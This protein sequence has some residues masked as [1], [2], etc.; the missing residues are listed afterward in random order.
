M[1]GTV[2]R[3]YRLPPKLAADLKAIA[4]REGTPENHEAVVAIR[5][6]VDAD[7]QR[8]RVKGEQGK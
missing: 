1:E 6:H 3:T 8:R 4:R 7:K 5:A 2:S